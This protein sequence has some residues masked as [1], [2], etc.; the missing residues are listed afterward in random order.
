M[1]QHLSQYRVFY[2]V[3]RTGNISH[4]AKE[5]YISQPAISKSISKLEENLGVTLFK[6]SSRGVTLTVEGQVL[7][8]HVSSA[9]ATLDRGE[10]ELKRIKNFNI[11]QIRFGVSNTLCKYVLLPYLKDFI[12]E[13]PHIR[14]LVNSQDTAH[15]LSAIENQQIDIGLIA[16]PKNRKNLYFYP[17]MNITDTFVCT[18]AYL[19]NLKIREGENCNIFECGTILMLDRKN[20][21][22]MYIDSY[23]AEH[24]IEPHQVLETNTL[25]LLISFAKTGLGIGC[26]VRE[27]VKDELA[28]GTLIEIPLQDPIPSR[29]IGFA[30]NPA[31]ETKTMQQFLSFI[32]STNAPTM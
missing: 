12:E 16:E 20:M 15:S 27:F 4:A 23:F 6:R 31:G 10:S 21:T 11:G 30:W 3:A 14:I 22:R 29:T 17:L 25:D 8:N 13:S 32:R 1:E 7:Y 5:L 2:A 18:R 26:A 19:D 28:D 9:F 24:G